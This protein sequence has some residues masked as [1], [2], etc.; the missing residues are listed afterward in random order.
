MDLNFFFWRRNCFDF[1]GLLLVLEAIR[2][3]DEAFVMEENGRTL[4]F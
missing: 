2:A 4:E 1:V 3:E